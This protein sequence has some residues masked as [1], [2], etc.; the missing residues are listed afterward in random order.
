MNTK[1]LLAEEAIKKYLSKVSIV[2]DQ[3]RYQANSNGNVVQPEDRA[4][5]TW[6]Y[7]ETTKNYDKLPVMYKGTVHSA[8]AGI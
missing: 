3:Q 2:T 8:N 4:E 6:Y 5:G 1:E 7:P